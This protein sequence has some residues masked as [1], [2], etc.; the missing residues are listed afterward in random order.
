MSNPAFPTLTGAFGYAPDSSTWNEVDEDPALKQEM[1]GG[2]M[3]S[4]R[5]HTRTPRPTFTFSY[6]NLNDADKIAIQNFWKNT[7]FGGSVIFD[8]TNPRTSVVYA[9]RFK[10]APTYKYTGRLSYKSW[11]VAIALEQV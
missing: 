8:W 7:V 11:T 9:V 2:Y 6:T 10:S 4:R 3:I 1:E 5:K